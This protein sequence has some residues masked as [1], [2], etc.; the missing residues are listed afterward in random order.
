MADCPVVPMRGLL[1]ADGLADRT[2]VRPADA[3][4]SGPPGPR[5]DRI[6]D[7]LDGHPEALDRTYRP[8]HLTGSA[9]VADPADH[10]ILLMFHSKLERWLQPGG[11]A[12]GDG[13]L[14]RVALRE[15][16][17]ET[18]IAGLQ[19]SEPPVDLAVH[20]VEPPAED[21]H[22]HHDVRYLVVAPPGA[23]AVGNH[24]SREIRWVDAAELPGM[25][26]DRGLVRLAERAL[27]RLAALECGG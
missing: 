11:H 22:E 13:D 27:I 10:R 9:L 6:L 14:A 24:E 3:V 26:V 1:D 7:L 18:G 19:I 12:D 21:P 2:G 23:E 25:G 4:R 15:A 8:G 20:L 5:R 17:E 16:T